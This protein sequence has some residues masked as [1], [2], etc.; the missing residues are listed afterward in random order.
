MPF[1]DVYMI[2]DKLDLATEAEVRAAEPALRT[3][4]PPGYRE[5]VTTLGAGQLNG[6]LRVLPPA[7][8]V[9]KTAEYRSIEAEVHGGAEE[10]GFSGWDEV[11]AG[12]DLLPPERWLAAVL[13]VEEQ[14]AGHRIVFHPDAPDDLFFIP[15]E[16]L[17]VHRAGSTLDEALTWFLETGPWAARTRVLLPDG[18]LVE[19]PV[20][21]FVPDGDRAFLSFELRETVTFAEVRAH[22]LDRARRQPADTLFVS[23]AYSDDEGVEGEVLHLFVKEY[24][25]AVWCND[26]EQH[27]IIQISYDQQRQTA[28]LDRLL[29]F[30]RDRARRQF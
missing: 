1:D 17:E 20:R 22:L 18:Q 26:T 3:R 29:A 21:Y 19:R 28:G 15:H 16:D 27:I 6:Q 25:G 10:S 7:E 14:D 5:Y 4:F 13:L 24:G 2:G 23:E 12:L 9:E 8:I 30:C 11:E